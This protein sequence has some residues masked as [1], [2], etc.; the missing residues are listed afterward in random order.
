MPVYNG[1][2]PTVLFSTI[3]DL[4]LN[5]SVTYPAGS[6]TL[7]SIAIAKGATVGGYFDSGN[8]V[9]QLLFDR[10]SALDDFLVLLTAPLGA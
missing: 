5:T 9:I 2:Y 7:D 3:N 1:T 6:Q 8:G 10:T 4:L